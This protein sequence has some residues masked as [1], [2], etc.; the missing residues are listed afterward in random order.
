[1]PFP[2]LQ[3]AWLRPAGR[4]LL[5]LNPKPPHGPA[6]ISDSVRFSE[7][8]FYHKRTRTLLVTDAVIYVDD[9]PPEVVPRQVRQA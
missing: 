6:G 2:R 8:A 4:T 1:M 5:P 9:T 7:V 3:L